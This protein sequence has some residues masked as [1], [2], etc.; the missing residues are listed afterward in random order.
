LIKVRIA[1]SLTRFVKSRTGMSLAA[2]NADDPAEE[3]HRSHVL[4]KCEMRWNAYAA[5]I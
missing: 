2:D 5:S 4:A 3:L 1:A